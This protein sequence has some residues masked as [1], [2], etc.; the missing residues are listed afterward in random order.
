MTTI[1]IDGEAG[2]TGLQIRERLEPRRDVTLVSI[3]PERRKDR[4]ARRELL[5]SV[6]I[7]ILCLPD[8]AA[9]EAVAMIDEGS[10][11]RVIDAS[12]AF[13][14]ADGWAYGMPEISKLHRA[15]VASAMRVAN[16]GC[17]PQ[18]L[19]ALVR[20]LI[21]AGIMSADYPVT[22]NAVSGYSGGGRK[23]IEDYEAKGPS[24]IPYHPYGLTFAHK[25]LSEMQVYA[26]T[27]HAPVF[28][29]AV[30]NYAQGMMGCVPVFSELLL[31]RAKGQDIRD[32]L[33]EAYGGEAFIEVAPFEA[34]ERSAEVNPEVLNGTN[35]MR[36][37]VFAND[38]KGH[39]LLM[40]IYDNLGKGAS[41]AAVQNLN[42]MI[43]AEETLGTDLPQSA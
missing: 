5:N 38:I 24:A 43:G 20:P 16:P 37:H 41:G 14:T 4:E 1:F 23:M 9:K 18:G 3:A 32:C 8:E 11:T 21:N 6:D 26:E 42:L 17:Y 31:K 22:Y 34:I 40:A 39:V 33:A 27:A 29:P 12:T 7:A 25:H 19:I 10:A 2:T 15:K 13:R 30:G 36:L 28:Q 35:R